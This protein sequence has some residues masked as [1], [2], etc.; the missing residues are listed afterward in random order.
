[1]SDD[2]SRFFDLIKENDVNY[3]DLRFTDPRGKW[4][5]TAQRADTIDEDTFTDG[6]IPRAA[7]RSRRP[8]TGSIS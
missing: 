8:H 1:M 2:I 6:V 3:L 7:P 5:H 4:Q